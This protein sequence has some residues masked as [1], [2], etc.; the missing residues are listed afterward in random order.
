MEDYYT[1]PR[2]KKAARAKYTKRSCL[3]RSNPERT[4]RSR[5]HLINLSFEIRLIFAIQFYPLKN[6][7]TQTTE[8][9]THHIIPSNLICFEESKVVLSL[10]TTFKQPAEEIPTRKEHACDAK[11]GE[12]S[13]FCRNSKQS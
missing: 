3:F 13:I 9:Q 7:Y 5:K 12:R 11:R 10:F 2:R 1:S 4:Y 6:T 8:T